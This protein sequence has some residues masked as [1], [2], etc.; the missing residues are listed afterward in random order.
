MLAFPKLATF[1]KAPLWDRHHGN[2]KPGG[3]SAESQSFVW[4]SLS[5]SKKA[6]K[7]TIEHWYSLQST[8]QWFKN[9]TELQLP[10][11]LE[12][13]WGSKTL[14][15]LQVEKIDHPWSSR[16]LRSSLPQGVT[17]STHTSQQFPPALPSPRRSRWYCT[18][19]PTFLPGSNGT[20][21]VYSYRSMKSW[22]LHVKLVGTYVCT[23]ILHNGVK[24]QPP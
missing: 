24:F 5:T 13:S 10:C 21:N 23:W 17:A 15:M 11:D 3:E 8:K 12:D 2:K 16:S 4:Y 7:N 20:E 19:V 9:S 18:M 22:P 6:S 14:P 1:V